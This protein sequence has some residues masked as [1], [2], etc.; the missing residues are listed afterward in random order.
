MAVRPELGKDTSDKIGSGVLQK[1]YDYLKYSDP[2][3]YNYR[4]LKD[5]G[6]PFLRDDMWME[7]AKR[8]ELN[9]LIY[10]LDERNQYEAG[11]SFSEYGKT[12][13]STE[14]PIQQLDA[15]GIDVLSRLEDYG[16]FMTYDAYMTALSIP[17]LDN[18]TQVERVDEETG[19]K[20]GNYTDREWAL[21]VLNSQLQKADAQVQ[22][23][24]KK[25]NAFLA[26]LA[27][28]GAALGEFFTG[29]DHFIND[30]LNVGEGLLNMAFNWSGDEDPGARFLY[31]FSNDEISEFEKALFEFERNYTFSVNAEQAYLEGYTPGS[32]IVDVGVTD[33]GTWVNGITESIGY[34][35]PSIL[36]TQGLGAWTGLSSKAIGAIGTGTFYTGIFSGNVKD[37]VQIAAGNEI[38][39][40]D[41]NA[42]NVVANAALKAGAQLVVEKVLGKITSKLFGTQS[43]LNRLMGTGV[44]S[45]QKVI[46]N[47]AA[48]GA[49]GTAL[50]RGVIGTI[51][52]GLEETFQD[53]SDG[54]ID[55]MFGSFGGNL[56]EI[57]TSRGQETISFA[58]LAQS[59]AMGAITSVIVGGLSNVKY[60]PKNRVKVTKDGNI[61][62]KGRRGIGVDET[63]KAY[64]M[65]FFQTLNYVDALRTMNEWNETLNDP[66][67]S[68]EAKQDAA[69]KMSIAMNTL[70]SVMKT[71]GQENAFKANDLLVG[72]LEGKAKDKISKALSIGDRAKNLYN[73]FNDYNKKITL[74]YQSQILKAAT[75]KAEK[76]KNNKVTKFDNAVTKELNIDD[77]DNTLAKDTLQT[78]KNVMT[79]LGA[80]VLIGTDGSIIT[81]SEKVVFVP[82][83]TLENADIAAIIQ[84]IAYEQVNEEVIKALSPTQRNFIAVQYQQLMGTKVTLSE[85]VTTLLFDKEFYTK[86]LLLSSEGKHKFGNKA[87]DILTTLHTIVKRKAGSHLENGTITTRAYNALLDKVINNLRTG[88]VS[89]ATKFVD[90]NVDKLDN[91][92]FPKELKDA[93]KNHR[94]VIFTKNVKQGLDT[95]I[96]LSLSSLEWFDAEIDKLAQDFNYK[97]LTKEDTEQLKKDVRNPAKRKQAYATLQV[98]A[99]LRSVNSTEYDDNKTLILSEVADGEKLI[100]DEYIK[101]LESL[102]GASIADL[103]TGQFNPNALSEDIKNLIINTTDETGNQLYTLTTTEDRLYCLQQ[104]LFQISKGNYT[105][106]ANFNVTQIISKYEFLD[107]KYLAEDGEI[108]LQEELA[109]GKITKIK[110]IVNNIT[111][112]PSY[113]ADIEIKYT[114]ETQGGNYID[115]DSFITI[116]QPNNDNYSSEIM[117]ELTHVA[118]Y[119][120]R[121]SNPDADI[122]SG[123]TISIFKGMSQETAKDLSS[124]I[125]NNYPIVYSML[126]NFNKKNS[127][128]NAVYYLLE[129]ELQANTS[130][131]TLFSFIGFKLRDDKTTLVSPDGKKTWSLIGGKANR[132]AAQLITKAAETKKATTTKTK[133]KTE[134]KKATTT[135]TKVKTE[136]KKPLTK[137]A[138][139]KS[140]T[141]KK[142]AKKLVEKKEAKTALTKKAVEKSITEKKEAKKPAD[143]NFGVRLISELTKLQNNLKAKY[144]VNPV[145]TINQFLKLFNKTQ[146]DLDSLEAINKL[147]I[148]ADKL[149]ATKDTKALLD[150][151][152]DYLKG[153][154]EAYKNLNKS[155][156]MPLNYEG[157]KA[158]MKDKAHRQFMHKYG[159][160]MFMKDGVPVIIYRGANIKIKAQ[161]NKIGSDVIFTSDKPYIPEFYALNSTN[162]RLDFKLA[163]DTREYSDLK[164]AIDKIYSVMPLDKLDW[165]DKKIKRLVEIYPNI[166]RI[167]SIAADEFFEIVDELIKEVSAAI[168]RGYITNLTEDEV[169]VYD[170]KGTRWDRLVLP[171]EI[172]DTKIYKEPEN[173]FNL[174][175]PNKTRKEIYEKYNRVTTD[176][177]VKI[178]QNKLPQYK[179]VLIKNVDEG[180]EETEGFGNDLIILDTSRIQRVTLEDNEKFIRTWEQLKSNMSNVEFDYYKTGN[181]GKLNT[182]LGEFDLKKYIK[183]GTLHDI[184]SYEL[185]FNDFMDKYINVMSKEINTNISMD[186]VLKPG[187]EIK[188]IIELKEGETRDGKKA[189]KSLKNYKDYARVIGESRFISNE[190]AS[191]S[192]LS[193]WMEPYKQIQ[194]HPGVADF[195]EGTTEDFD[196]LN[197][198]VQKLIT[199]KTIS[200]QKLKDYL[201]TAIDINDYTYKAIMK[202]LFKN[203]KAA[204]LTVKEMTELLEQSASFSQLS[205]V[206]H[207]LNGGSR[208]YENDKPR[209]Y[210]ALTTFKDKILDNIGKIGNTEKDEKV[211]KKL[212]ALLDKGLRNATML[213]VKPKNGDPPFPV[214]V[215]ADPSLMR[216]TFARL[217]DGTIRS[218]FHINNIGKTIT[219]NAYDLSVS[220]AKLEALAE[221]KQSGESTKTA[222]KPHNWVENLKKVDI[223]YDEDTNL[224]DTI[225]DISRDEK[226]KLVQEY[227]IDLYKVELGNKTLSANEQ[228]QIVTKLQQQLDAIED[229][230]DEALDKRYLAILTEELES[231]PSPKEAKEAT[232]VLAKERPNEVPKK[233]F[234]DPIRHIA[235]RITKQL[236]G[237]DKRSDKFRNNRELVE[238]YFEPKTF[239][240]KNDYQS[241]SLEELEEIKSVLTKLS[242]NLRAPTQAEIKSLIKE[243]TDK[244]AKSKKIITKEESVKR[245]FKEK[246]QVVHKTKIVNQKIAANSV[247]KLS[248]TGD[249]LVKHLIDTNWEKY[250]ES[251]V[252]GVEFNDVKSVASYL[253]FLNHNLDRLLAEDIVTIEEAIRW[254]LDPAITMT[255]GDFR[256]FEI[257]KTYFLEM[258]NSY[259]SLFNNISPNLKQKIDHYISTTISTDATM[260]AV[261]NNVL[262]VKDPLKYLKSE[263]MVID[264]V[265][266]GQEL[267]DKLFSAIESTDLSQITKAEREIY[268]FVQQNKS[269]KKSFLRKTISTR[270]MMMLS[271][272]MTWLR[273]RVSNIVL[274]RL[275]RFANAI[276]NKIM[277]NK[278]QQG[279]LKLTAQVT[280]DIQKFIE[281][282]FIDNKFFDTI[283]SNISKYNP[284]EIK[285]L[286]KKVGQ[287]PSKDA[288]MANL[289]IKAMYG[290]YY[291]ENMYKSK[292]MNSVYKFLMKAMSDDSYVREAAIRYFGKIIAE[293]GYDV[294]EGKVTDEIMN[295]LATAIGL[296]M[297]DYMHSDN[298]FNTLEKDLMDRSEAGW[299]VYKLILPFANSSWN[300]FK[301]MIKMT[302]PGLA[303]SIIQLWR[304]EKNITKNEK[305]WREGK[306]Q[307]NPELREYIIRR[308]IGMGVIG[309]IGYM[310]GAALAAFGFIKLEDEDYGNPKLR[311]GNLVVDISSIF[312]SSSILAGA[313]LVTGFTDGNGFNDAMNRMLDVALDNF[314]VMEIMEL[315][316]Y[317]NGTWDIFGSTAESIALSFIPNLFSWFAGATYSGSVKKD[318]IWKRALAKIPFMANFLDKTVDPYTGETGSYIDAINRIVPYFS[319]VV[320]SENESKTNE[321]GLN[322]SQLRGSYNINGEDFNVRGS[323]LQKINEYYGKWNAS[324]LT[325][326][327]DNQM[328]VKVKVGTTYK[329]LTYN[330]M[331]NEQ[332]KNAVQNI[333]SNNA[334]LAKIVAWTRAGYKYY[335]SSEIYGKLKKYGIT[336]NIFVGN[337]GFV[338]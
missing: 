105:L 178:V 152:K 323:E 86:M 254:F 186:E 37:T 25:N 241:K 286:G 20:Y 310:L 47:M 44:K 119:Q 154:R 244:L 319:W 333:M 15:E 182:P 59:F 136:P 315:D 1:S 141:E 140:I 233:K 4:R 162:Y 161:N 104:L 18:E 31:A 183:K 67:S 236:L 50:K 302:P 277:K 103:A 321:L 263:E 115:G 296:A 283:V 217:Y 291:N 167:D 245:T 196:K 218:L 52:E 148:E 206:L 276:G 78:L 205:Y 179:A 147:I 143:T 35:L 62:Y 69:F 239:K 45:S 325:K 122:V 73:T 19:Y 279:Q 304:L 184:V 215:I 117:H 56:N 174:M 259:P 10:L 192:N 305:L 256:Q 108:K 66:K 109:S 282:N 38:S 175:F 264:N 309:T 106:D 216:L 60:L 93:V 188:K 79:K 185:L 298:L 2:S 96:T 33:V 334:E 223:I 6:N 203:D 316:M 335:G 133:V 201:S 235:S 274:K 171:E 292:F 166:R 46:T 91:E 294:K 127:Y 261:H 65:G 163:I 16:D 156:D 58:N 101:A 266:I 98:G 271:S 248:K 131:N 332:R 269:D 255:E 49:I 257:V 90:Y 177:F 135:K 221:K 313:A 34:M 40:K 7:A 197:T 320:A 83:K 224:Q 249:K 84:G 176:E 189:V 57:Y 23:E 220:N 227:L 153:L 110:D 88:I 200:K 329:T 307:I 265:I 70:G 12:G 71:M 243:K 120:L 287:I 268:D 172:G 155:E 284:S 160:P 48:K 36:L 99:K 5:E 273:N 149:S 76:L 81:K 164:E 107:K 159:K 212:N 9:E 306:S 195:I 89:Y 151:G 150:F 134:T 54:L 39:Y 11:K 94:N 14:L 317:S 169:Y 74:Q 226:V 63:G 324:D 132:K 158:L 114:P 275:N 80:D 145:T 28:A 328:G 75:E 204:E 13:N 229:M 181:V 199:T 61:K 330:Q 327:Y 124:Y 303:K 211:S 278:T 202:H 187:K 170:A 8:G 128:I 95:S 191:K 30:T 270:S 308:D 194:M 322:K 102:F 237:M 251:K 17:T 22:E 222:E 29:V 258:I 77:P 228:M 219:N 125:Y 262:K 289:V 300:W 337:K 180:Q 118:Q 41:L 326:F 26:G 113:I 24:W 301:A 64:Q 190:R 242:E 32:D 208:D 121:K 280:T 51:Q 209:S 231:A 92:L 272:P 116:G 72:Y 288:V 173:L 234:K 165:A 314:P 318:T 129:G 267:K 87:I 130:L 55:C 138:A 290:Q 193:L 331:T 27:T 210:Y 42:G 311:I 43:A 85:A 260:L 137:K 97:V 232:E 225:A 214:D 112:I 207:N 146:K 336:R 123:G 111:N 238:Q 247:I 21:E 293:K 144:K 297:N 338:K 285:E 126:K 252:Q 142:E 240:L 281:T 3:E 295:S 253:D 250:T 230:S 53:L 246:I 139:E 198:Y 299:F 82:N 157:A 68:K 213:I 100:R 168:Y 312:G